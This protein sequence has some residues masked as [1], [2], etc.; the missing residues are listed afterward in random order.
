VAVTVEIIAPFGG[1]LTGANGIDAAG[2]V[3]GKSS[4]M[5]GTSGTGLHGFRFD[6][7]RPLLNLGTLTNSPSLDYS[8][9]TASVTTGLGDDLVVGVS[10]SMDANARN[11]LRGFVVVV[12]P[13]RI[14]MVEIGT[15]VPDPTRTGLFLGNSAARA[16][17]DMGMIVGY[18]DTGFF[19]P[20]LSPIRHAF[21]YYYP[22]GPMV[23]LGTLA[24]PSN[25]RATNSEAW[26]INSLGHIVG[27]SETDNLDPK[28]NRIRRAF[29]YDFRTKVMQDLGTLTREPRNPGKFRGNSE[30]RAINNQDQVVGISDKHDL[31]TQA[32]FRRAF[33][34][35]QRNAPDPMTDLGALTPSRFGAGDSSALAINNFGAV[36]GSAETGALDPYGN[37]VRLAFL[38]DAWSR[39]RMVDL[40]QPGSRWTFLEA[41]GINDKNQISLTAIQP[42]DRAIR[43]QL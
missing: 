36:V 29:L 38:F 40:N 18:S 34:F 17:N 13:N 8:I 33:L 37:P 2:R 9:A 4:T 6:P 1:K 27:V 32:Q 43:L 14:P 21:L 22:G 26:G 10:E 19:A 39:H 42:E 3:V 7:G 24:A 41:N 12:G 23:D 15:L 31:S 28:G 25:Q 16:V 20:D 30:A 35:D 5:T 11:V